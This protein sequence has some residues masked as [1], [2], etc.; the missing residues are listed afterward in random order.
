MSGVEGLRCVSH[1]FHNAIRKACI[2]KP[3]IGKL[4]NLCKEIKSSSLLSEQLS[5]LAKVNGKNATKVVLDCKWRWG[6]CLKMIRRYM[7]L[8]DEIN[9]LHCDNDVNTL[10][11]RLG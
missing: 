11:R 10:L 1:V 8:K 3:D 5:N 9:E 7:S 6:Y 4:R 2:I